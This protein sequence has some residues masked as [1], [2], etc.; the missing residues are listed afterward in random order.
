MHLLAIETSCDET[1]AAVAHIDASGQAR[2]LSERIS[3]QVKLHELYGGVVPE[4]AARE[5]L[6][7]LPLMV[8]EALKLAGISK[9][10]L[11]CIAVTRG[12]GLKGCLLIGLDYA[13]GLAVSLGIPMI[14][15][16][17]IEGHL[18]A[19]MMDN[20]ELSFPFL[21]LVV[22]GGHTE[23]H[24]VRGLGDYH[25]V[26]RTI[27]DAA[28]EAFDKSAHLLGFA[29]PGG[30][31]LAKLGDSVPSSEFSLPKVMR[32][33]AGFSF[34]GLKT[35]ISLLISKNKERF[36]KDLLVRASLAHAIQGSIVDALVSKL[37]AAVR[38]TGI[39]QAAITGGVA[40]NR[41]L[42]AA[43]SAI[44]GLTVYYPK[45]EHCTDNAA[46]IAFVGAKRFIIGQRDALNIT[47]IARWP[48]EELGRKN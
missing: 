47:A 2:I 31:A 27:D 42:R 43:A 23:I 44:D 41:A 9:S 22:S 38:F 15:V 8:E 6:S 36:E 14:G 40:A 21:C 4:L 3:S 13:K 45:A 34:S 29:Y 46:M 18:L 26:S 24:E 19:P 30:A 10:D 28:G 32:H 33:E 11:G 35:A 7:N 20:P 39:R 5:H 1:A 12:P 25:L 37:K 48:V 17:H 16:N